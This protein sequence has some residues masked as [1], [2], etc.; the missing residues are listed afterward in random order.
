MNE[1]LTTKA[2]I[3]SKVK[4]EYVETRSSAYNTSTADM[5][6][7]Y[8]VFFSDESITFIWNSKMMHENFG[9]TNFPG[10]PS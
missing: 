3:A 1:P 6:I 8:S 4:Y 10:F 5:S 7:L 9:G 2:A